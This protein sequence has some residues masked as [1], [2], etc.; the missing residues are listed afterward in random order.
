MRRGLRKTLVGVLLVATASACSSVA[1]TP[2]QSAPAVSPC[3]VD[4]QG[5]WLTCEEL[6]WSRRPADE[7]M[8]IDLVRLNG[9]RGAMR[10]LADQVVGFRRVWSPDNKRI[11]LSF[12]PWP[13]DYEACRLSILNPRTGARRHETQHSEWSC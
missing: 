4:R 12:H 2:R 7:T 5:R 1:P 13:E 9:V 8:E 11:A 10:V 6:V 3:G